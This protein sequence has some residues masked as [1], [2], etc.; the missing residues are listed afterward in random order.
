MSEQ[1]SEARPE[2]SPD[3]SALVRVARYAT[4]G[5]AAV[6]VAAAA[7]LAFVQYVWDPVMGPAMQN[8]VSYGIVLLSLSVTVLWLVLFSPFRW[9]TLLLGFAGVAL[10]VGAGAAAVRE[11]EFDGDMG[12]VAHYRWEATSAERLAAHR[13]R[14]T[15]APTA[16]SAEELLIDD[17]DMP[18]Y[19]GSARDGIVTGPRLSQ[20]WEHEPPPQLWRQ[21]CGGGY[22]SFAVVGDFAVTLEQR[23]A[24]EAIVCY[25]AASGA[26]RWLHEYPASFQEAMGG[27]GPRATPTIHDGA[28]YSYGAK[29]DLVCLDLATGELRW[30][31]DALPDGATNAEWGMSSSPLIVEDLAI[32]EAGGP[33]GDGL[34]AFERAGGDVVWERPGVERLRDGA[35]RNRA[36]YS[37]PVLVTIG[38]VRQV[39]IFDG[40]GLRSHVPETGEELWFH[41]FSNGP[42][43]NV[44]QPILLD[45]NR[46]FLSQSYSVGCRMIEVRH[47]DDQWQTDVLWDNLN[48]KC[49]FTSPVLHEG[50]LYGLDEGILVCL[51]PETGERM[52]K[53]GRYGHGQVLLT[54]GQLVILSERGDVVLVDATPDRLQEI[55]RFTAIESPKVWNPHA[56]AAG[57]VYVRNHETMAA[58]DLQAQ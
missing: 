56:L 54:H 30:H 33:E 35:G 45:G 58:Y 17:E 3:R 6:M 16:V 55:T 13:T 5:Y 44:A 39:L 40:E 11:I 46:I 18:A 24:S 42:G 37:S 48:M 4:I 47:E 20:D 8:V 29:G 2:V 21:P 12:L 32:V 15:T 36:G 34:V 31:A 26:E 23:G 14:S 25:S 22:A 9:K 50:Y 27:P 43:V 7:G 1:P 51:D 52:W 41:E 38:G 28:V 57:I 19:R 53:R 10:L 49:K